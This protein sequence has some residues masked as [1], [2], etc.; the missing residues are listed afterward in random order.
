VCA[1]I[2]LGDGDAGAA[3]GAL[4]ATLPGIAGP[5]A[6]A[7]GRGAPPG[8]AGRGGSDRVGSARGATLGAA[9]GGAGRGLGD[10]AGREA[11]LGAA[12]GA[13]GADRAAGAA[14]TA[15]GAARAGWASL[16]SRCTP[17]TALQTEQRARTPA[18][19]TLAGS[20]RNTVAQLG[21]V[22]FIALSS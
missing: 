17:N 22:T 11:G 6:T 4:A 7:G 2:G 8:A 14:D 21:Q 20:T 10:A 13:L 12:G 5:P 1:G 15:A 18:S 3:G 19:G 16:P 9:A